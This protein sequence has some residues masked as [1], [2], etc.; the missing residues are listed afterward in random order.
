VLYERWKAGETKAEGTP[1]TRTIDGKKTMGR[2]VN[3]DDLAGDQWEPF[4]DDDTPEHVGEW[5]A[6]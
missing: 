1:P 3:M 4:P 5:V 2:V 6:F